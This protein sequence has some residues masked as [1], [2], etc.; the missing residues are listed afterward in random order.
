MNI[1]L[2]ADPDLVGRT[3]EYAR[4]HGTTMNRLIRLFMADLT[5]SGGRDGAA[6]EFA[7]LARGSAGR[8]PKGYRFN[9]ED[10][11]QRK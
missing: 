11:H 1:T 7:R 8:S 2:S 4:K 3:R 6:D 9:R 10:A 5:N